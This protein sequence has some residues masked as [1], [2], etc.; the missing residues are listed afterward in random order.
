M[1]VVAVALVLS[2]FYVAGAVIGTAVGFMMALVSAV[3]LYRRDV[4]V[5]LNNPRKLLSRNTSKK[6]TFLEEM[7]IAKM[8]LF[9]SIP[10][11]IT[12]LAEL[13]LYDMGTL[14][15]GVYMPSQ[16]VGYYTAA[17]PVARLPLIISMAVAT[18]VLPA[19]SE[20]M[21]LNDSQLLKTYILQSYRY[22]SL[23]VLPI[24]VGTIVFATP[25]MTLIN[26][27]A[28]APGS[29]ALQIL[30]VGML[31]FTIYTISSSISQGLGKPTL[32]MMVLIGGTTIDLIFSVLLI[33]SYGINGAAAATTIASFFIMS[34]LA[35]KTLQL[36]RVSLPLG[37]FG[38][39]AI[40]SI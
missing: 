9:F 18:S 4:W 23:V 27:S 24:C 39:I 20:A 5:L 21:S 26:G 16:F 34:V 13:L 7:Q 28:Y 32:P 22:V 2:G 17:S 8:L 11:V 12:G 15:V 36:A 29:E 6:F 40:A 10:V 19:T 37:E 38:K 35:Y 14:V 33:P 31:F 1:I 25:I 3:Y 30:A